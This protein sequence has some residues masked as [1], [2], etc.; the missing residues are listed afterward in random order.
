MSEQ[1]N[2]KPKEKTGLLNKAYEGTKKL[3]KD[4]LKEL[5]KMPWNKEVSSNAVNELNSQKPED[6]GKFGI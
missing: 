2:T 1:Q 6:L 5:V 3:V 4:F